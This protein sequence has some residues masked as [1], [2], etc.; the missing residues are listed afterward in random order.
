MES[1][2]APKAYTAS[3]L[4]RRSRCLSGNG[5]PLVTAG[6]IRAMMARKDNPLPHIECGD[7]R[8]HS[9][10]FED[11]FYAFL[12]YEMGAASYAEVVA[13][14]RRNLMGARQ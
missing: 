2:G 8:P 14:A 11:V 10:A 4:A 9:Y 3:E 12:A 6:A 7:K 13:R 1:H 5:L